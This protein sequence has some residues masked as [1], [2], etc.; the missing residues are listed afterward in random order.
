M[1]MNNCNCDKQCGMPAAKVVPCTCEFV[2]PATYPY[3][4]PAVDSYT[5]SCCGNIEPTMK[6]YPSSG[7]FKGS[8]FALD[9]ANPYLIDSTYMSYGQALTFAENIYTQVTKR[10]D[11]SCINLTARFDMT[12]S[13]LTNMVRFDFL[14][15]YT[16]RKYEE[17]S[18]VLPIIK[19]GIKFRVHY[20]VYNVD[21]GIEYEGH[22]DHVVEQTHFH[23]TS[24]K[25]VFV[26]SAQGL[27]I[28][29]IPAMTFQGQ[30]TIC[31]THV[32]AYVNV[33]NTKDHLQ[34]P[35]L[36]PYYTF[37]DNNRKIQLHNM[38][39]A[40]QKP[41]STLLIGDCMVQK[42][43]PYLANVTTRL[44]LSFIAFTSL[45]IAC[46]DTSPIWFALNEPTEQSITQLRNEVS[47]MEEQIAALVTRINNQDTTIAQLSGQVEL[48]RQNISDLVNRVTALESSQ[49]DQDL[50][51]QTLGERV[52]ALEAIPLALVSYKKDKELVRSQ[53]TW[54][55]YGNLFQCAETYI[56]SGDF[57]ADV[58]AGYL[59]PVTSNAEDISG[60]VERLDDTEANAS[61]ALELASDAVDVV[62]SIADELAIIV[63][64]KNK[65][66][67]KNLA[68]G[69]Y[70]FVNSY[71]AAAN[72][73]R[74][75]LDGSYS[76][77]PGDGYSQQTIS[78][79]MFANITSLSEITFPESIT[80][81]GADAFAG[82]DGII[83]NIPKSEDSVPGSPWGATNAVVN[84]NV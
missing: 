76:I 28:E 3:V 1:K 20:I 40:G 45:P 62:N 15:N 7:A 71:G 72:I 17:L 64:G 36:N 65:V 75:D 16:A 46:G 70:Q 14:K 41:D 37:T 68:T 42:S 48:N 54:K 4:R 77:F 25:D 49:I 12:D 56:P 58:A 22:A 47:A 23:F 69:E 5:C 52:A 34:D 2:I 57:D 6:D 10:D 61:E 67:I 63:D 60:I 38:E 31:I 18:G 59:V 24:I 53:I 66:I 74:E 78:A 44:R 26:Q 51:I 32:E 50:I 39:I 43:F 82:C 35:S 83:I 55:G 11:A 73:I 21:G 19:N 27:I 84:W 80:T 33:I 81:I 9:N 30:Y 13:S 8:A 79:E 29:N